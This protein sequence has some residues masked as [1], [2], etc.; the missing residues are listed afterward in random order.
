M[1]AKTDNCGR[2]PFLRN[3]G[4]PAQE[5]SGYW[6]FHFSRIGRWWDGKSEIDIAAIDQEEHNL[7]QGECKFWQEPVGVN[8]LRRLEQKLGQVSWHKQNRCV[9]YVLFDAAGFTEELKTR[10][11]GRICFCLMK[12]AM[13]YTK[14]KKLLA[15]KLIL[16]CG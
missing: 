15:A 16:L 1:E 14:G 9:W 10:A 5:Y 4:T 11:D 12:A 2:T 7:V 6:P 13:R 8:I 3:S